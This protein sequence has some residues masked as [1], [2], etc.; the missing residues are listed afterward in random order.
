MLLPPLPPLPLLLTAARLKKSAG[1]GDD[2]GR[3]DMPGAE[4]DPP[5]TRDGQDGAQTGTENGA[6]VAKNA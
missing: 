4:L 1:D 5:L 2:D 3:S 6:A